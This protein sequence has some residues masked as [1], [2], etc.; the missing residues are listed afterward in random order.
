ML[1]SRNGNIILSL[2]LA[3]LL[4][5]YVVGGM[6]PTIQK[7]YQN[8]PV[9]LTNQQA[10]TDDELAVLA[11]SDTEISVTLSGKRNRLNG[12][13]Q[14]KLTATVDLT[15]AKEGDNQLPIDIALPEG[16]E[17]AAQSV[18]RITVSVEALRESRKAVQAV[19]T[20]DMPEDKEAEAVQIDPEKVKVTGA[21]S[22]VSRVSYVRASISADMLT[23]D[24]STATASLTPVD[25]EGKEVTG[26]TLS[27]TKAKVT[28]QLTSI[29]QVPLLVNIK[30]SENDGYERTWTAPETVTV[31]GLPSLL[32]SLESVGTKEVDL[33]RFKESGDFRLILDL[34]SGVELAETSE[35]PLL[36]V[37]VTDIRNEKEF[38]FTQDDIMLNGLGSGRRAEV[39]KITVRVTVTASESQLREIQRTDLKL[40]ADLSGF[41]DGTH[42]VQIQVGLEKEHLAAAAEPGRVTVT[43][44]SAD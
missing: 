26:V 40:S 5:M 17:V 42:D 30:E 1:N 25:E 20:G 29:K 31:R 39:S 12:I 37:E 19:Y 10:L 13:D 11:V 9:T 22:L 4:W 15:D 6:N 33:S 27:K 14:T 43:I 38:T 2:I 16:V 28:T 18:T 32:E 36:Q 8:I 21:A 34:P 23:G 24:Q 7:S 3:I 44:E 35:E 41:K